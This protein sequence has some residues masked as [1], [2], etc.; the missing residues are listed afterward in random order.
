MGKIHLFRH[1]KT[2]QNENS[3]FCGMTDCELSVKK[4][5]AFPVVDAAYCSPLK[6]CTAYLDSVACRTKTVRDEL[7]EIDFGLW[8]G[9]TFSEIRKQYPVEAGSYLSDPLGFRF[10]SGESYGLIKQRTAVFVDTVLKE[11]AVSGKDIL[12]I[13]HEGIIKTILILLLGMQDDMFFRIKVGNESF[14][15]IDCYGD[16]FVLSLNNGHI[17]KE[18]GRQ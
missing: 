17:E 13:T 9:M 16:S 15:E 7:R 4:M 14:C 1:G 12:L 2:L 8:E 5:T 3:I 18:R 11:D 10:P 6:R